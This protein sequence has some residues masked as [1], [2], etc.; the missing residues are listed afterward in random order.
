M[1]VSSL[2]NLHLTVEIRKYPIIVFNNKLATS[3]ITENPHNVLLYEYDYV[4]NP[5]NWS[6]IFVIIF[7]HAY[8]KYLGN[9]S[10]KV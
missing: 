9:I 5:V 7:L 1:I 6:I 10:F 4:Q 8:L 3:R 2:L